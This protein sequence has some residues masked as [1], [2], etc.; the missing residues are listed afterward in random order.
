M[1][2]LGYDIYMYDHT[3]EELPYQRKKFHFFK[4]G[5]TAKENSDDNLHTLEYYVGHNGHMGKKNM[6]LKIDVEGAEW[7]WLRFVEEKT[8]LCFEQIVMELHGIIRAKSDYETENVL[9]SLAKLNKT[10]KLVHLHANN[11][12]DYVK[13]G[14]KVFADALEVTYVRKGTPSII[15]S[16]G[17]VSL[18]IKEDQPNDPYRKEIKHNLYIS[19][20]YKLIAQYGVPILKKKNFSMPLRYFWTVQ[21]VMKCI[22]A[23]NI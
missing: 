19:E 5:I 22:V 23:L 9:N 3:I 18:P 1:A 20:P 16:N 15:Y 11:M 12:L 13:I 17:E 10:H 8:L 21:V 7:S 2:D 6:V 14:D 4:S